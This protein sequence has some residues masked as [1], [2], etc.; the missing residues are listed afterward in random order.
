MSKTRVLYAK[1]HAPT[2]LP[3]IGQ[4]K[5]TLPPDNSKAKC[6]MYVGEQGIELK[7]E[8]GREGLVPFANVQIME[9]KS[10]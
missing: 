4:I 10:E 3:G 5:D 1:L 7:F 6:A 2:F 9:V 8:N